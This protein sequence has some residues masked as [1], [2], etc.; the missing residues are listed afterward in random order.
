MVANEDVQAAGAPFVAA[1]ERAKSY[2]GSERGLSQR[3]G[4][5]PRPSTSPHPHPPR[6]FQTFRPPAPGIARLGRCFRLAPATGDRPCPDTA[7][8]GFRLGV[9]QVC[10]IGAAPSV[11]VGN[12]NRCA[13][14]VV[15]GGSR[16]VRNQN[17][18]PRHA[19]LPARL[20][21]G[22]EANKHEGC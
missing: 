20:T 10:L 1:D 11:T 13:L 6:P 15:Y 16:L 14:P 12:A 4:F 8:E 7:S 21:E 22:I 18:F 3:G 9:R 2:F 19:F 5:S 17:C